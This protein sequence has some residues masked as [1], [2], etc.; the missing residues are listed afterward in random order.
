M[1]REMRTCALVFTLLAPIPALAGSFPNSLA[2]QTF[3]SNSSSYG[4]ALTSNLLIYSDNASNIGV[5]TLSTGVVQPL[6]FTNP[7]G[8]AVNS[9]DSYFFVAENGA[10]RI[11]PVKLSLL[12][13]EASV[14]V[15]TGPW[16]LA[17]SGG[18]LWVTNNGS[19]NVMAVDT[20]LVPRSLVA[21][22]TVGTSPKGIAVGGSPAKIYVADADGTVITPSSTPVT[23]K[24]IPGHVFVDVAVSGH[25]MA[26]FVEQNGTI[27]VMDTSNDMLLSQSISATG[28]AQNIYALSS[29]D[30]DYV[31]VTHTL[32]DG[33]D[34]VQFPVPQTRCPGSP[35]ILQ[36]I[37]IA[38]PR[39]I[40]ISSDGARAYVAR[41]DASKT[42]SILEQKNPVVI[43][44]QNYACIN[45]STRPSATVTLRSDSAGDYKI[46]IGGTYITGCGTYLTSGSIGAN[47][48]LQ[49]AIKATD[50]SA[51]LA[52]GSYTLYAFVTDPQ[53]RT[54]N[55]GFGITL[56][57]VA[58]GAPQ[59]LQAKSGDEE[60]DLSW[61]LPSGG[62]VSGYY[63]YFTTDTGGS[64]KIDTG[65]SGTSYTLKGLQ[66]KV[67]YYFTV[68]AYD[69]AGNEG[70]ASNQV[71]GFP[72]HVP[73][74]A[75]L[76]GEKGGCFIATEVFGTSSFE[77]EIL[78][79]LRD[80]VLL[81]F[82]P[83]RYFVSR[84]YRYAPAC[85][86]FLHRHGVLKD[87]VR[88]ALI[89]VAFV[90][91]CALEGEGS[92]WLVFSL[93]GGIFLAIYHRKWRVR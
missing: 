36:S 74:P 59:G 27:R 20:S 49:V 26:Y 37:S 63:I 90:S 3:T 53:G 92:G 51:S 71:K 29:G 78:R 58:P 72:A 14:S 35:M 62:D 22:V 57:T 54:G 85:S 44:S 77:V 47:S 12:G 38:S 21:T 65:S 82:A 5:I 55:V 79:S 23:G 4:L 8:L 89:P 76:A 86:V 11:T 18:T 13:T 33:V 1:I 31:Y 60:V 70:P 7:L 41:S 56:D 83:G 16:G 40:V 69:C 68:T 10:A 9:D 88:A 45:N 25:N 28:T 39:D 80:R 61:S 81:P 87:M 19:G 52:N 91:W 2:T 24:V 66:N 32:L 75:E 34:I 15:G 30:Y 43:A 64:Q 67:L 84:Y 73:G 93:V 42:I 50:L 17:M 6:S 46:E 48:D